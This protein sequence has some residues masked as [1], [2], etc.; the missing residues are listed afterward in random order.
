MHARTPLAAA[1]FTLIVL[2]LVDDAVAHASPSARLVFSRTAEAASCPDESALRHAV[3][4]RV[5]YDPFFPHAPL[6]VV[7]EMSRSGDDLVARVHL[8]DGDSNA[9]GTRELRSS[10][11]DCAELFRALALAISIAIDP[12][13]NASPAPNAG[14]PPATPAPRDAPLKSAESPAAIAPASTDDRVA[15][16]ATD[17][18]TPS[19]PATYALSLGGASSFGMAPST[20]VGGALGLEVR[21]G[22]WSVALEARADLPASARVDGGT[23]SASQV[24]GAL[25]PCGH[26]RALF[27]CALGALGRFEGTGSDVSQPSRASA[28]YAV[29]GVRL[30]AEVA[31]VDR[32]WLRVHADALANLNRPTLRLD[33]AD[34]WSAPLL[35]ASVGGALAYHFP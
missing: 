25:I 11:R 24:S 18:P 2:A 27:G 6:T 23:V 7:A 3:A 1:A 33:G 35:G 20:N 10:Q 31:L 13:V 16:D 5:G 8:V 4:E 26:F 32:L 19:S 22:P 21:S 30:G 34:R 12:Q 28:L 14:P 17:A 15:T 29:A 9:L